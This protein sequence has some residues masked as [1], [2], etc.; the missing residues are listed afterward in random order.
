MKS[1]VVI[2]ARY[3]AARFPGKP[4]KNETGW[5]LI[6]HVYEQV[7][8]SDADKV[9]IATDD[10]RIMSVVAGFGGIAMMTKDTH[11]SGTDRVAEVASRVPAFDV[12]VNVQGDE[13]EIEPAA[14]NS[15]IQLQGKYQPFM[16]TLCCKFPPDKTE[17]QGSPLDPTCNKVIMG[18]EIAKNARYAIYF[19]RSPI[20]YPSSTKGIMQYPENYY[21]HIGMYAYSPES[22]QKFSALP[23]GFLETT[24]GLEQLRIIEQ[25]YP[26]LVGIIDRVFPGV[27]TEEDYQAFVQRWKKR[28]QS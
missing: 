3:Q 25:G 4:L 19:S 27:D 14:I 26:I 17:G 10:Q 6:R 9:I 18:Q 12:I 13:P 5:P 1:L 8:K 11:K 22:V 24:E 15:L 7:L 21:L 2:P 16:S 23:Q 20:P 28:Q